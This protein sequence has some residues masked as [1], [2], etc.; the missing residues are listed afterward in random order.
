M[1][2]MFQFISSDG[3][4]FF[5]LFSLYCNTSVAVSQ[6]T[7]NDRDLH[8][9]GLLRAPPQPRYELIEEAALPTIS[10]RQAGHWWSLELRH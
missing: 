9:H 8:T 5:F 3:R 2:L 7:S 10:T 1:T 4:N 6:H